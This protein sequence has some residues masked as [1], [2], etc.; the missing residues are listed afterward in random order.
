MSVTRRSVLEQ[1]AAASDATREETITIEALAA[2][3]DAD[4]HEVESHIMGLEACD[5][6]RITPDGT[7]RVTITGEELLAL[8]ADEMVIVDSATPNS[9]I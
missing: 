8:D 4:E 6:A 1:L 3:L 5:L 9:E 7:A 2:T